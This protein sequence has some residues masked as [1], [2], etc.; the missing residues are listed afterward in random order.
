M[1][2]ASWDIV[3]LLGAYVHYNGQSDLSDKGNS[4]LKLAASGDADA[5]NQLFAPCLPQLQRT[6]AR[7]LDNSYDCEDAV[8]DSLLSALR[9]LDKF[10]GRA[11]FSTWMHAIVVNAA[12]SILRK[13]KR[14]PLT[15]SL[16]DPLPEQENLC[17]AD[18]LPHPQPGQETQYEQTERS[19]IL[20]TLLKDLPPTSRC[21]I[22]LCDI[23]GL[24][25]KEAAQWLGLTISAIKTRHLRANRLVLKAA[26]EMRRRPASLGNASGA[27]S[28][29]VPVAAPRS[30]G[31][32]D[33]AVPISKSR[34][35]PSRAK[36]RVPLKTNLRFSGCKASVMVS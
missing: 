19:R 24:C 14:H 32:Q 3:R 5:L 1:L 29:A 36:K 20:A 31:K 22:W 35:I 30:E 15:F 26:K 33:W 18:T 6:A 11:Q 10:E 2:M 4:L 28:T 17:L 23:Q 34:T 8:Q 7:L 12:K 9:H 21:V 25:M 27:G 16:E 13:Q